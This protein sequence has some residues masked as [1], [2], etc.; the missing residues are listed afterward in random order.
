MTEISYNDEKPKLDD[1][2]QKDLDEVLL[3]KNRSK[4]AACM[5][6][7]RTNLAKGNQNVINVLK[8]SKHD[9]EKTYDKIV[10]MMLD[11]CYNNIKHSV[12][13]KILQPENISYWEESF[14]ELLAFN[15]N[16]FQIIGPELKY[17]PSE[18]F[19]LDDIDKVV[20][21]PNIGETVID[22]KP[23]FFTEKFGKYKFLAF[24]MA[25]GFTF[26]FIFMFIF[27]LFIKRN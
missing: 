19:I 27:S 12:V 3:V 1:D 13:E 7:M 25:A 17:I 2:L 10:A 21:N 6:I 8:D 5:L 16:V 20:A 15:K 23:D 26:S 11:N 18:K 4:I 24:G 22:N 9:K 14:E